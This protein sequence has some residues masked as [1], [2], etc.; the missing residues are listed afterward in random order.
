MAFQPDI[1]DTPPMPASEAGAGWSRPRAVPVAEALSAVELPDLGAEIEELAAAQVRELE[2]EAQARAAAIIAE[3]EA[4][5]GAVRARA[6]EDGFAAG[7]AEG[8]SA[9]DRDSAGVIQV[10]EEVAASL[11]AE[12]DQQLADAESELVELSI[13]VASRVLN[14]ALEV[15]PSIVAEV[16][17]GALRRAFHRET[18]HVLAHPD[19]LALLRELGPRVAAELGGVEHLHFLEERRISRG[20]IVVRTPAGEVDA[21]I[22]GKLDRIAD[23]L[24]EQA[25]QRRARHTH[26]GGGQDAPAGS[27]DGSGA[28]EPGA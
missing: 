13:H 11:V 15:D 3:A 21:T 27:Q 24:R 2:A 26:G 16:F 18:V 14:T 12:R 17:R 28:V 22:D 7:H 4:Q 10:A 25:S 6:Y 20:S 1:P 5:A 19:D 8:I 9:A 23:A